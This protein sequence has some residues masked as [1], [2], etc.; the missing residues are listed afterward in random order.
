MYYTKPYPDGGTNINIG[1]H[2]GFGMKSQIND[3]LNGFATFRIFS[4]TS[5]GQAE[6]TNPALDMVGLV[7]GIQFKWK[8]I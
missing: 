7:L 8:I 6:E 4:H 2:V 3:Y 1:T 5:N